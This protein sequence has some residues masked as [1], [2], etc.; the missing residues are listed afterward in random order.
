MRLGSFLNDLRRIGALVFLAGALSGMALGQIR[1]DGPQPGDV[2]REFSR[3]M[4]TSDNEWWRVTDPNINL[5]VYPQA[6]GFL[7]NPQ[8]PLTV[9]DLAGAVRAEAVITMWGGHIS[10][11][12]RKVRFNGNS[13]IN[14]PDLDGSN[15][16]PT[17][18]QGYNYIHQSMVT[19]PVPLGNLFEGTNTF[20]GTNAG[21]VSGPV[22]YGFG[23]G[24][25]GW[26]AIMIR[27]YYSDSKAHPTGTITSPSFGGTMNDNPSVAV[28]VQGSADRVDVLAYYD[29]YDT[30]GDGVYSEYHYDYHVTGSETE[31]AI[32]N[33]VGTSTSSPFTVQWNTQWVPDQTAGSVKLM[34]RVRGSNGVWY[35]T[36]EVTNLSLARTGRSVK[37]YKPLNTPERAWARGDLDVVR[38]DVNIPSG[39]NLGDA[40]AAEYHNRTW[41]GIDGVREP[42]ETNYR[43][44]NGWTDGEYGGNHYF[45]YDVRNVPT[46]ELRSGNNQFSFYSQTVL[47][48]GIEI[49]WPG[50]ALAVEYTGSGYVSPVPATAALASPANNATNQQPTLALTWRPAAAASSYD[51]QVSTDSTF[52]V[53]TVNLTGL[54]DTSSQVGPLANLTRFF[55]RVR[56]KNAAG[57]G[58]WSSVWAFN[59]FVSAPALKTPA[60]NATAQP[61][62][63]QLVWRSIATATAYRVQLA[64]DSIFSGGQ[65]VK[66]TTLA[67]TTKSV[68]GLLNSTRYFWRVAAQ[69]GGSWGDYSAPWAFNTTAA[70]AAVPLQAA[71]ANNS[72][73]VPVSTTVRWHTAAS[74][75]SYHVQVA[76]DPTFASG[77]VANDSTLTDTTR[78][79]SG[80]GYDQNYFWRVRSKNPGGFSAFS[81]TWNFRTVMSVANAPSLLAPGNSAVG[82][83]TTGLTFQ[84][85]PL[86][87]AT[88]YRFQLATD[89]TFVTGII[90]NDSTVTDTFRLVSGLTI[91]TKYFWRVAGRNAGGPG[92]FSPTWNFTTVVPVPGVVSLAGPGNQTTIN[93][94][95]AR[96]TWGEPSPAAT[97]YWFQISTDSTFGLF[98]FVD[99]TLTAPSRVFRPLLTNTSYYWRVR[100]GNAGGWGGYSEV[101]R[102][103]VLI[104]GIDREEGVPTQLSLKQNYPNPFNPAT[105]ISFGLPGESKVLLEVYNLL[106]QRV[107]T[108]LNERRTAGYHTV[109]FDAAGLPSG[110]YLYRLTAGETTLFKK[111]LLVK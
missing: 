37:L 93:A 77:F 76:T 21:Q 39:Q 106:G 53:T 38:V 48:H 87:G 78:A 22:G 8:V 81:S 69:T 35:V 60:N 16:I 62:S 52:A 66:D 33:H 110:L 44:L 104:T 74:A 59:T 96:F 109:L 26:Y 7:P 43:K 84:W 28:S 89:S 102:F 58:E 49:I 24:Q 79:V 19:V 6:A 107:A 27:V 34:A 99:S 50:P 68:S 3:T 100:G 75:A 61:V 65:M 63:I 42:G 20:E 2:Y 23:W 11:Y 15:G 40:T 14:I 17:G 12:G 64:K 29:G 45:S 85:R 4:R 32:R 95:S 13:W 31:M 30:D 73:D 72:I 54:A 1:F 82:Q 36:P 10:T 67:D 9:S 57:T 47:H 46:S 25:H 105:Q 18:H 71:P 98:A 80:L 83:L 41:N 103:S 111:M 92:P 97:K 94:D 86:A 55:W 91:S 88:A 108:L 5:S 90:K 70:P 51:L 101:R 56:G